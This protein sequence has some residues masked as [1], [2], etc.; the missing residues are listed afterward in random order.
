MKLSW[1]RFWAMFVKEFLQ[2]KR[3]PLTLNMLIGVPVMQLLMFG[4]AINNDP[5]HLPAA[6]LLADD[7]SLTRGIVAALDTTGYF[8]FSTHV[9][10]PAEAERLL[11]GG[12][13]QF[14]VTVPPW[15]TRELVRG[16]HP[17]LLIESDASDPVAGAGA[18][19]A[20]QGA[21]TQALRRDLVG[22]LA[23]RAPPAYPVDIVIHNTY[24]PEG[25]TRFNIVPGLIGVVLF[26]TLVMM[27]AMAVTRE[28][29][30]GTLENL[31]AMPLHPLEMML[32]KIVPYIGIGTLQ[33]GVILV[34][35]KLLFGVPMVGSLALVGL[36]TLLFI[37][38]NLSLGYTISTLVQTQMQASQMAIVPMMPSML[39]SGFMFPFRGMP[40]WAQWAGKCLPLTH[41]LRIVRGTLLK[42]ATLADATPDL[43]ALL[44]IF[45]VLA[46]IALARYK[47]TID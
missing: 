42:G 3:D 5:H 26:M 40:A 38:V 9:H 39:L 13:V 34:L 35:A 23:A 25:L 14:A 19:A 45:A 22:P 28:R 10:S 1:R 31:L 47:Q 20:V 2:L 15:F 36:A 21:V 44:L 6:L 11:R 33:V 16:R 30:R 27:M 4:Y 18:L 7:T 32:G 17:Q 46:G 37:L 24:N 12:R 41:Y 29:E 43:F 8:D